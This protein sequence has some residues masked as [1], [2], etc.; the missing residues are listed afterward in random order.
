MV[1]HD[2]GPRSPSCIETWAAPMFA[3]IIGMKNGERRSAPRS[4][5]SCTCWAKVPR[6]PMPLPTIAP[7]RS[8]VSSSTVSAASSSARRAA[9]TASWLKRSMRRAAFFSM[10]SVGSKPFTSQAIRVSRSAGSNRVIGPAPPRP[11]TAEAHT[12]SRPMP[13][14]V[15]RPRPVT[16]TRVRPLRSGTL[17]P[18][19]HDIA[20]PPST[21]STA[22]VTKDAASETRKAT[23]DATSS[24]SPSRPSGVTARTAPR[25]SSLS[26]AV[27]S[28]LM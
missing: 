10:K 13:I 2:S 18:P 15:T 3:T 21:D 8:R 1:G 5:W 16:T 19:P 27:M 12:S 20:R 22:P 28:V 6:P 26:A 7:T 14:G 25:C 17:P 11:A 4:S 9:A 23:A 24:G